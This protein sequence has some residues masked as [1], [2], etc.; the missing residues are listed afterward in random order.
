MKDIINKVWKNKF[1]N[2]KAVTIPKES[3]IEAGDYVSI[4]K[5]VLDNG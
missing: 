1:T 4:K 3:D 5:V 2:Q